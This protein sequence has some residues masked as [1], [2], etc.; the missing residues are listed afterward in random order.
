M[1]IDAAELAK[2]RRRALTGNQPENLRSTSQNAPGVSTAWRL[3]SWTS[4]MLPHE[5][6]PRILRKSSLPD[7]MNFPGGAKHDRVA[8]GCRKSGKK[9]F[10]RTWIE[11]VTAAVSDFAPSDWVLGSDYNAALFQLSYRGIDA[12]TGLQKHIIQSMRS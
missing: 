2:V 11:Q 5:A 12:A 1:P 6:N 7:V 4:T 9:T 3:R 8:R 10:P